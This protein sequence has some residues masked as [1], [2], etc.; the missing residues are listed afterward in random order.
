MVDGVALPLNRADAKR[1]LVLERALDWVSAVGTTE[2]SEEFKARLN[3]FM[4]AHRGDARHVAEVEAHMNTVIGW[5]ETLF[6][7][8]GHKRLGLAQQDWDRLW[9]SYRHAV[10]DPVAFEA[11]CIELVNDDEVNGERGVVEFVLGGE[12]DGR[13]LNLRQFDNPT[14]KR[15]YNQQTK[16]TQSRGVSNCPDC[17]KYPRSA[18]IRGRGS[19][20]SS[21]RWTATTCSH[22]RRVARRSRPTARC[23]ASATTTPS[24]TSGDP[25][26]KVGYARVS[27][28]RQGESLETQRQA[29]EAAGCARVFEDVL[30]GARASRPGLK[31]A[32]DYMRDD[33]VLVVTRLDRLG[34]TALDTLRTIEKLAQQDVLVI[35]LKPELDT[36]T[37]EGKLMVTFMSGLAEFE[38]D[39][40]DRAHQGRCGARPGRGR[41]RPQAEALPEQVR[42]ARKAIEAGESVTAVARS[43]GV[44]RQTLYRALERHV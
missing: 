7:T 44:S 16:D 23:C 36:R 17:E 30:S 8:G 12:T 19:R 32:L 29:L 18:T 13:L 42:L 11:R 34:R 35:V 22:G 5:A 26:M 21:R 9:R 14:K 15:V 41:G 40:A 20:G 38:R 1:Q 3:G 25:P 24:A 4:D 28:K 39:L 33:D 43:L 27:T 6:P 31:A 37:K 10:T 2:T